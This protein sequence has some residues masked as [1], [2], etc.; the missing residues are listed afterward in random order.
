MLSKDETK[1]PEGWKWDDDWKIDLSRAVDEE[2]KK[3]FHRNC[4]F[5]FKSLN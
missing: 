3:S 2:G 4:F 5:F 1:L